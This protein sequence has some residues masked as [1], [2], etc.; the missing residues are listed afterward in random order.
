M[1]IRLFAILIYPGHVIGHQCLI[2]T[3]SIVLVISKIVANEFV[4]Q[5]LSKVEPLY[6]IRVPVFILNFST[7]A[8]F[9]L[10]WRCTDR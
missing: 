9:K 3:F 1:F 7:M 8:V 2:K 4:R 10:K 6:S 5:L